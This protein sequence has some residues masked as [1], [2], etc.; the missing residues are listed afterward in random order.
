MGKLVVRADDKGIEP[1]ARVE[2]LK[3]GCGG[4]FLGWLGGRRRRARRHLGFPGALE[5]DRSHA[6][7]FFKQRLFDDREVIA[8]NKK[9][10]D[11]IWHRERHD[12]VVHGGNLNAGKPALKSIGADSLPY[13][14]RNSCPEGGI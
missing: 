4:F 9:L 8:L 12:I 11:R 6:R 7:S 3:L 10:V 13:P 14:F 2:T 5:L 1:V